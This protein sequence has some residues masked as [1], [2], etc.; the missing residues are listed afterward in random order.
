MHLG[1]SYLPAH[2][3]HSIEHDMKEIR[4]MGCDRVIFAISEYNYFVTNGSWR[5]GAQIAQENGLVPIGMIVGYA[6]TFGGCRI[7]R[8]ML[9]DMEMWMMDK[10]GNRLPYACYN[11]PKT[12]NKFVELSSTLIES[13]FKGIFIDEPTQVECWCSH[14]QKKF[15]ETYDRKL[16]FTVQSR[17]TWEFKRDNSLGY[18]QRVCDGVKD[19]SPTTKMMCCVMPFDREYWSAIGKVK[20]LDN[21]GTDPYWIVDRTRLTLTQAVQDAYDMKRICD[22]NSKESH[23]WLNGWAIPKGYEEEMYKGGQLL[24]ASKPDE[25]YT[26]QYMGA[27]GTEEECGDPYKTWD[28]V[29]R[30]YKELSGE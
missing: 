12:A 14:C 19:F 27:L 8:V 9:D 3:P 28:Y 26:W 20:N 2:H 5:F 15:E 4:S 18:V 17:E 1:V 22:E 6:N 11:N 24:A 13:G 23:I 29:K 10:D 25:L 16:D 7:T 30:L 21:F